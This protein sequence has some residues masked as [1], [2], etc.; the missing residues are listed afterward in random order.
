M[1]WATE[2]VRALRG[3]Q[4]GWRE[5]RRCCERGVGSGERFRRS[6]KTDGWRLIVVRDPTPV[7]APDPSVRLGDGLVVDFYQKD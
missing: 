5:A 2:T 3:P 7:F 1:R 4:R 6:S